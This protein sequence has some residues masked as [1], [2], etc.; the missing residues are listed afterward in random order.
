MTEPTPAP[1]AA[2]P[3]ARPN[4]RAAR[5]LND[6][7]LPTLLRLAGPNIVVMLAQATANFLESY[8]VGKLGVPALAGAAL[9]VP[10]VMA[11]QMLSAG[12]VGG[13]ISSAIA[14][15]L[16]AGRHA[17][18]EALALHA[19]V[20]GIVFG[21]VLSVAMLTLG[22]YIYSALGGRDSTLAAA[23]TYSNA[24]FI[25]TTFLWLLNAFASILRGT[26]NMML[27][28]AVVTGG[29]LVLVVA[30]P[31][32]IF[33]AGPIPP[34][35]IAGAGLALVCYYAVGFVVLLVALLRGYGGIRL[36]FAH[37]LRWSLFAEILGV[38]VYAA[39]NSLMINLSVIT[40][41]AM[42]GMHGPHA[43]AGFGLG[44]RLEYLL[45]PLIFGFGAGMVAM[46]GMNTGAGQ[47]ARA[48]RV[49][50]TG[51]LVAAALCEVIGLAAAIWPSAWLSLF[52]QDDEAIRMGAAYLRA[53]APAYGL[54]GLGLALYF[55]AQG[56]RRLGWSVIAAVSR[57]AVIVVLGYLTQTLWHGE[58]GGFFAALVVGLAIFAALNAVPWIRLR[59]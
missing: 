35:G 9:V 59:S 3:T 18:A 16:G 7:I 30:S 37:R 58:L 19:T 56:A 54:F 43:L 32:L 1:A 46:V 5:L 28:A 8:Y 55:A 22:P 27:P 45:V 25:G 51:A 34:M 6:P 31:V 40:A 33:G 57:V 21:V 42:V 24:V 38:G 47:H 10:L 49:A 29:V 48:R 11:M 52:T 13:A 50:W 4:A 53:V 17:E 15:A 2:A 44:I 39:V 23:V 12:A 20:I 14:R 36:S 41:T 26:G